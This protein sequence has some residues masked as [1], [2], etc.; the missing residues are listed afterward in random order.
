MC[1]WHGI[2]IFGAEN[3]T[4][5]NNT[6]TQ[7]YTGLLLHH[8]KYNSISKNRLSNN[9]FEGLSLFEYSDRN[10]L[11]NN[12]VSYNEYGIYTRNSWYNVV[13]HNNFVDNSQ[14]VYDYDY[15]SI[16]VWDNGYPSG[17][18]YWSDYEERYPDAEELDGSGIWD[19]PYVIDEYNQDNYPLMYPYGTQT[20]KL[21]IT[22]TPG[23]TTTPSPGT[24]TYAN[25]TIAEVTA[26]PNINYRLAYWELDGENAGSANPIEVL[27]D[28]NHTLHVVFTPIPY[29]ELTITTTSEGKTNPV[30]G[31]TFMQ[32]AH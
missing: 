31:N 5:S 30:L 8:S 11:V 22:T 26:L 19:T 12:N 9:S 10:V 25:G 7:C 4:I 13:Y 15:S 24:Q 28:S 29:Y 27:M 32:M 20:Y 6:A 23:G 17:G 16:N 1:K 21:T 14:Q 18:N 3:N 2:N